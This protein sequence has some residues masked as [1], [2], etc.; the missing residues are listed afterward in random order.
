MS[1]YII[2]RVGLQ[3]SLFRCIHDRLGRFV[4]YEDIYC[5]EMY[6]SCVLVL[7]DMLDVPT[8]LST[9]TAGRTATYFRN[10]KRV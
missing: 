1:S 5:T 6:I 7:L 8:I 4:M 10:P 2:P 9:L 3:Q